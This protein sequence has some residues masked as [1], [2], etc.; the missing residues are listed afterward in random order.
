MPQVARFEL[1][2]G[3]IGRFEVPDGTTPEQAQAMISAQLPKITE[4]S[5]SPADRIP[6]N[7]PAKPEQTG[8][9]VSSSLL[10][11]ISGAA[12]FPGD[13]LNLL[14]AAR[15]KAQGTNY[16]SFPVGS[17]DIV[18][19]IENVTGTP[20]YKP[21]GVGKA[22]GSS[23]GY[24]A[25]TL[26]GVGAGAP[27]GPVGMLVGGIGGA[28]GEFGARVTGSPWGR[29]AANLLA[30]GAAGAYASTR[31]STGSV[32]NDALE[33]TTPQQLKDAQRLI[34]NARTQGI[35]L[36]GPEAIAQIK[37][38]ASE[39]ITGIQ[40]VVE[41]SRGGGPTMAATMAERPAQ[42]RAAF[43][44]VLNR[45][46]PQV[47]D[48]TA[49]VSR[50]QGAADDAI[51]AAR[52]AGNARAAPFYAQ[53]ATDSVAGAQFA[54]LTKDP[55]IRDAIAA[56]SKDPFYGVVGKPPTSI[57]VLDAAKKYLD[58]IASSAKQS[59]MN[60]KARIASGSIDEI[61]KTADAASPAYPQ[62]RSIV[63]NNMRNVV[64]PMQRQPIGQLAEASTFPAQKAIL[65]PANPET[66]TPSTVRQ[67]IMQLRM[68]DDTAARDLTR[69]F[70]QTQFDEVTQK[71]V[72][73]QNV[74]GGAKFAS[75]IAGNTKQAENIR[76]AIQSVGGND[77]LTGF[78]RFISIMEAQGKRQP[79]GSMT[80][81]NKQIAEELG[82]G[83]IV[84]QAASTAASPGAWLTG[85]KDW[86]ERFKYGGNTAELAQLFTDPKSVDRM[87]RL[88][89]LNP[90]S[91][92]ARA[93]AAV[94][95][96][97]NVPQDGKTNNNQ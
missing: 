78:N 15:N 28:A 54:A 12:G 41:Q 13:M 81:F 50:V 89:M 49:V 59:G 76:A 26:E 95:A 91:D 22:G 64:E 10:R 24:V 35:T 5:A 90:G 85:A 7:A 20:L 17:S 25:S 75:T 65:F 11:G 96:S 27:F 92:R 48:P 46:G 71:L 37:G 72:S 51:T 56:V 3:R 44:G 62:A 86:Y 45:V 82:R 33:G 80:E 6:G 63:A 1:P 30:S 61:L 97:S 19:G 69:Q 88:A 9:I 52:Q 74:M 31:Q 32:L 23:E 2:D 14:R 34:D 60:N 70:L 57:A 68:R 21:E 18:K 36:T 38:S 87:K 40:R 42:N 77:A 39:P 29:V 55:V 16:P 67:T 79:A 53:A 66:L 58:D 8:D 73:G 94:I 93:L 83:G 84:G 43:E 4:P 47:A